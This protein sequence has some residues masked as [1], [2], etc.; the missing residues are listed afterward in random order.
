MGG[1]IKHCKGE[2]AKEGSR[3]KRQ[4]DLESFENHCPIP[5]ALYSRY[6]SDVICDIVVNVVGSGFRGIPSL[7]MYCS[8]AAT[9]I[10]NFSILK[11]HQDIIETLY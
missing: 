2:I 10:F 8:Y 6:R 11:Q 7:N 3:Y 9:L 1:V 4:D 5:L